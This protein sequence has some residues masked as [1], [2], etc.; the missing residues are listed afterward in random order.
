MTGA[1]I[2]VWTVAVTVG[3]L[4]MAAAVAAPCPTATSEAARVT[5]RLEVAPVVV[6]ADLDRAA[7]AGIAGS[8]VMGGVTASG[9]AMGSHRGEVMGIT[10]ANYAVEYEAEQVAVPVGDGH[11]CARVN[12]VDA[13]LFIPETTVYVASDYGE[14]SC[15]YGQI[16]AH[17]YQHV[18][19]TEAAMR[20][21]GPR[22]TARL[23]KIADVPAFSTGDPAA[24]EAAIDGALARSIQG[25]MADLSQQAHRANQQIDTPANYRKVAAKCRTW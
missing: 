13:R 23:H 4:K 20:A 17:E 24:A 1:T 15:P 14:D 7:L 18:A 11:W 10:V 16:L 3:L 19:I 21:A 5:V 12:R 22:L 9:I 2:G 25:F 6:R 8:V